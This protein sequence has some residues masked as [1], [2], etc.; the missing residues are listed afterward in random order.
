[1]NIGLSNL[2]FDNSDIELLQY[3]P[4]IN[5]NTIE[6]VY[7]KHNSWDNTIDNVSN[8]NDFFNSLNRNTYSI[9]SIFYNTNINSFSQINEI[10]NH[11]KKLFLICNKLNIKRIVFGSPNFRKSYIDNEKYIIEIFD[12]IENELKDIKELLVN[13]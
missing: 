3:L 12:Y 8:I 9:Q 5:I 13:D 1:M 7:T 2:A 4:K 10:K 11:L 6:I